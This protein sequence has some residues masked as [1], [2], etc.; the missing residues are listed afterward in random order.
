M[1]DQGLLQIKLFNELD[2][3]FILGFFGK[4][5]FFLFYFFIFLGLYVILIA[6][7]IKIRFLLNHPIFLPFLRII[8]C[9]FTKN[10]DYLGLNPSL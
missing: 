5:V 8:Y 3:S 4:T 10:M 9:Y 2:Y 7:Y 6:K 1:E